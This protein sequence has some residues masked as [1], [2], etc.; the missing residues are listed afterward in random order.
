MVLH[1]RDVFLTLATVRFELLVGFYQQLFE[2]PPQPHISQSYAEFRLPGLRL[3][4]FQP[5]ADHAAEFSASSSGGM[6]VCVEVENLETAI[7]HLTNM[8]HAPTQPIIT[9]SHGR[10]IYIT[11]PDGNRLILHQSAED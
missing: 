3:A 4:I 7:A 10:E 1:C 6:S 2:Q 11:D 8:G 9:A 5:N